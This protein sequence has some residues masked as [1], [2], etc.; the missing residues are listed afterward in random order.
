MKKAPEL[1]TMISLGLEPNKKLFPHHL[2]SILHGVR[3]VVGSR[4]PQN[5]TTIV[6]NDF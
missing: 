1:T 5:T 3:V 4:L 6:L 2:P